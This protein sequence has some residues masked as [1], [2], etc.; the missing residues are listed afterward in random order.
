MAG[1][2]VPAPSLSLG[3]AGG[4]EATQGDSGQVLLS[5]SFPAQRG[6]LGVVSLHR[7]SLSPYPALV[8][9]SL[10]LEPLVLFL[11]FAYI[12]KQSFP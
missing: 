5:G 3:L 4:A 10:I 7:E 1:L 6:L 2:G 8:E 9:A 11:H 12:S